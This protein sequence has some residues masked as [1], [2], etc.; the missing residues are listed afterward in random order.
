VSHLSQALRT[1][2]KPR[3]HPSTLQQVERIRADIE[4]HDPNI[5]LLLGQL[6][7]SVAM[8]SDSMPIGDWRGSLLRP[9]GGP[10]AGRKCLATFSP[11]DV[12]INW[13]NFPLFRHDLGR[14]CEEVDTPTLSLPVR[15]FDIYVSPDKAIQYLDAITDVK[16]PVAM[17]IE[18]GCRGMSCVS[19]ATTPLNAFIVP[20]GSYGRDDQVRVLRALYRFCNSSTPKVL[21]NQLYD[22]FVL[23]HTYKMFI[24]SADHIICSTE[25]IKDVV[26]DLNPKVTVIPNS[27]D[28]AI[29]K[30]K[31]K[32][33]KDG[34]IRIGWFGSSS[35][36]SDWDIVDGFIDEILEKYPQVEFHFA[37]FSFAD[38][39]EGRV[40]NYSGTKGYEEYPQFVADMDLDIALAPLHDTPFNRCKS[41][42]KFLEHAMLETPMVLSDVTP[43]KE[44]VKNYKTGYLAKNKSQWVKY[45]S[46]LIENEEKRKE[47]GKTAKESVLKDWTIDKQL[48]K[49]KKLFQKLQKKNITVYKSVTGGFDKLADCQEDLTANYIAF[50]DQQSDTWDCKKPYDKFKDDRRNSRIQKIIPHL[51]IDT[52]YSIYL[53]GNIDLKVPAQQLID[54]YLK[55]KDVAV[56]RHI[57]R[58]CVYQEAEACQQLGKGNPHELAEQVKAYAKEGWKEHAGLAECGLIIRRHTKE[59]QEWNEKWWA[60]YCRYSERDQIS[61]PLAFP[62]SKV[63]LIE[64]SYWRH[65]YLTSTT[66]V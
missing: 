10:F 51:F 5:V 35:H 56:I 23:T 63:A 36:L 3:T 57:G 15:E 22:N 52:E 37:G 29:W 33:R 21:Q 8:E 53:D 6:A 65:P 14:F 20:F 30:V 41:N 64:Q 2:K 1:V 39:H 18:G 44:V 28:P 49:Y 46:W 60:Q 62:L 16:A 40:F 12:F 17:D 24:R 7:L 4:R 11:L 13:D 58:D 61:F 54:E 32:K 66:H 27:I 50:T 43:Y 9:T 48:P 47:I 59:V 38:K 45:L 19:F 26:K 55:D 25:Y 34:K 42:I 31:R